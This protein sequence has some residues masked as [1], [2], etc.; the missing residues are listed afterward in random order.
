MISLASKLARLAP[1]IGLALCLALATPIGAQPK[2]KLSLAE[3][4]AL[5]WKLEQGGNILTTAADV[6][7]RKKAVADLASIKDPRT[8]KP[9]ATALREDPD[10]T[11]RVQ[12]AEAL[13]ALKTPEAKGLLTIA[14]TGDPDEKVRSTATNLLKGFPKK[15]TAATLP[16]VT[17]PFVAPKTVTLA[18]VQKVLALPSGDARVW[19]VRQTA[20]LK[21]PGQKLL[22]THLLRDPSGRVRVEAAR[23]LAQL[24]RGAALPTL[25]K[26][27]DDGDPTVRFRL[28]KILAAYDDAGSLAV[29]QKLASSD[30]N[31]EV[32][33]EA[34]D[35][36]EPSTVL[37]K[38][39]LK[40]RIAKLRSENPV[41]RIA[42][43]N[44]LSTST[45]WRTMLPMSCTLL[46][47]K[48]VNVRAT[49]AKVLT[50]MHD[51]TV[52]TAMRVAA[53]LESDKKL[54][55]N[56]QKLVLGMRKRV[57]V[58]VK[59]LQTGD[60]KQRTLAARALGQGAYPPGLDPLIAALKDKEAKVR[61]AAVR[62]LAS[63]TDAKAKDAL[64]LA[65]TDAEPGVRKAVD[66]FFKAQQQLEGLRTIYKDPNRLVMR[67]TDK[68]PV[69]RFDAAI[70]LGV[71]GAEAAVGN[72]AQLLLH[73]KDESVRH[74]AAWALVLMGSDRGEQALKTAA[75]K[76]PSEKLRLTA[77]K[78]LVIDKVSPDELMKQLSDDAAATRQ[79]AA[80]ALSLRASGKAL[81]HLIRAAMCDSE[82][83]VRSASL[84]GLA[85]IGNPMARSVIRLSLTRDPEPRVRRTAMVMHILA[86][87][88]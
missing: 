33:A 24:L 51:I 46:N 52:Q 8:A 40:T 66:G 20:V 60:V 7:A 23:S 86:G 75:S 2:K 38:R 3:L 31:E 88:K 69:W 39:L 28:A 83:R 70:A 34:A 45:H 30:S 61:L 18:A 10:A 41:E 25:I 65:G 13:A 62:A 19:A 6:A 57:D 43:L 22:E 64:K 67:T 47:D 58:L 37:G 84:R 50:D 73:D 44:E 82:Q 59:Q 4:A 81:N 77:R 71:A 29:I 63:F 21:G 32:K 85:R 72:L 5:E 9:L 74:A 27:A 26:A 53:T 56:V 16:H 48:S 87:G 80:E 54:Q 14:S 55:A 49:A 11:V 76:D 15:L 36:L 12:A 42:A 78:Y 79:D 68:D 1:G 17:R 35:L